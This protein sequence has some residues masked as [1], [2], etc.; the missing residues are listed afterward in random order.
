MSCEWYQ[1]RAKILG[2]QTL[3]PLRSLDLKL[4]I[5]SPLSANA[6]LLI[7]FVPIHLISK[8]L[9]CLM[10]MFMIRIVLMMIVAMMIMVIMVML[11]LFMRILF[12]S[13]NLF[14]FTG[15]DNLNGLLIDTVLEK[16]VMD[17]LLVHLTHIELA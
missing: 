6:S 13:I 17:L 7:C 15:I 2:N 12:I 14:H 3:D 16:V 8:F 4:S 11:M 5:V 10:P 9:P 1:L